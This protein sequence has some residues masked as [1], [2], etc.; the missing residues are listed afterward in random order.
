[1][2]NIY[3]LKFYQDNINEE[4]I[5][6]IKKLLSDGKSV[7]FATYNDNL[8]TEEEIEKMSLYNFDRDKIIYHA[9]YSKFDFDLYFRARNKEDKMNQLIEELKRAKSLN[10]GK[11]VLHIENSN[12]IPDTSD[13]KIEYF[14]IKTIEIFKKLYEK[15]EEANE[16]TI[17]IENTFS[18]IK[19]YER[20]IKSLIEKGYNVGF[21]LDIGHAKIWSGNSLNEWL[22]V[23]NNFIELKIPVHYHIHCNNGDFDTHTPLYKGINESYFNDRITGLEDFYT[24]DLIC[25]IKSIDEKHKNNKIVSVTLEVSIEEAIKDYKLLTGIS[26]L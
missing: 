15:Y 10:A 18:D 7:E 11:M 8:I 22:E 16:I 19:Y 21:T 12:P 6:L 9:D 3:G 20:V 14:I 23:T 25:D 26:L 4:N 13:S 2:K 17:L 24:I 1:M 5:K